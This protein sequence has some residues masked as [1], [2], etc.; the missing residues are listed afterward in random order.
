[1]GKSAYEKLSKGGTEVRWYGIVWGKW[2]QPKH[3]TLAWQVCRDALKMQDRLCNLGLLE[4]LKCS[5]YNQHGENTRHI[6][7]NCEYSKEVWGKIKKEM[8][9]LEVVE[10]LEKE[11]NLILR[12]C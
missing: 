5:L 12:L 10:Y 4:N 3:S 6:Y 8:G 11:W 2:V 9:L 7:F 1:M